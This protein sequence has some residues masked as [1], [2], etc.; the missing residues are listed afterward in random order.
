M[1]GLPL[2]DDAKAIEGVRLDLDAML[3]VLTSPPAQVDRTSAWLNRTREIERILREFLS[4]DQAHKIQALEALDS[5]DDGPGLGPLAP[6]GRA[7]LAPAVVPA[8]REIGSAVAGRVLALVADPSPEVRALAIRVGAK[9]DDTRMTP[10]MI[11]AATEDSPRRVQ[12]AATFALTKYVASHPE[13]TAAF[14]RRLAAMLSEAGPWERRVAVVS[15]LGC[16]GP[17]AVPV[18][19]ASLHDESPF[20]RSAAVAAFA[21]AGGSAAVLALSAADS[22]PAVRAAAAR[23][24]SRQHD[25]VS[26][27]ILARLRRDPSD[28]VRS[29]AA[30]I[31]P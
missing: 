24:L 1:R 20:V 16:L 19:E 23:A 10:S 22:T 30:N 25:L 26:L 27:A 13:G 4:S 28:L 7:P 29:T 3:A 2:E 8:L 18:L 9:L 12:D 17:A 21:R 14:N 6:A 5:R 15:L 31:E 11:L